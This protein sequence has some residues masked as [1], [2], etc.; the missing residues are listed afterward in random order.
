M[1]YVLVNIKESEREKVAEFFWCFLEG[2]EEGR[3][4]GGVKAIMGKGRPVHTKSRVQKGICA[5]P[6]IDRGPCLHFRVVSRREKEQKRAT[7]GERERQ[8]ERG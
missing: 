7:N 5:P 6:D 4:R 3:K 8:R 2:P 1:A